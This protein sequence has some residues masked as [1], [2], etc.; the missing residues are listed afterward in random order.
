[1][2]R[3]QVAK[4]IAELREGT[5]RTVWTQWAAIFTLPTT[6]RRAS[7]IVDPEALLLGSFALE[8][9]ERRLRSVIALWGAQQSRLLSVQRAKNLAERFPS[10]IREAL[11]AFAQVALVRG[12]DL[13]WRSIARQSFKGAAVREREKQARPVLEGGAAIM[14]RLRLGLGVGIKPDVIAY[15]IGLAGGRATVQLIAE[16]T[17]YYG[18]AVRRGLEELAAAGFVE[19]RPTAPVSYRVDN[20]RWANL[21]MIDPEDPPAWRAWG[22]MY[23]FVAALDEWGRALPESDFVLASEAR[24]LLLQYGVALEGT[25]RLPHVEGVKGEDVLPLFVRALDDC[26]EWMEAVV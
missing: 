6:K 12:G 1:M 21:L 14:L 24:D 22:A 19:P 13:R 9:Q 3:S 5:A 20:R 4:A 18:R 26:R 10:A 23:A 11:G 15:L 8:E 17:S 7:A 25:A 16:A 2:F